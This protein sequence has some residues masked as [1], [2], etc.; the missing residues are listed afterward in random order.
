MSPV[1][2]FLSIDSEQL[3]RSGQPVIPEIGFEIGDAA[4]SGAGGSSANLQTQSI[5]F[6]NE[7]KIPL[8]N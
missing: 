5:K 2:G 6:L 8:W 1:S 3:S 4:S 7:H